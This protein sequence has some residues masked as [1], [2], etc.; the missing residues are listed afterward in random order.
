MQALPGKS[1]TILWLVGLNPD[2]LTVVQR[3][4]L[5]GRLG[6]E[7]MFFTLEQAV[8]RYQQQE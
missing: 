4:L 1:G 2:V 7:Q 3:S 8:E 6:R 5:G